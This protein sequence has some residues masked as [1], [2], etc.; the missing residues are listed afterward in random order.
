MRRYFETMAYIIIV[1]PAILEAA[2]LPRGPSMVATI[3]S[4]AFGSVLMGL[5]ARRPFAVAPYMGENAFIA[6]MTRRVPGAIVI[7]VLATTALS[8]LFRVSPAP[9]R[10]VSLPPDP[11]PV[12]FGSTSGRFSAPVSFPWSSR[13]S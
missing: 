7:G 2:G 13:S 5:Y 9:G 6:L 8:F 1:N 3:L 12:M 10:W 11:V 4:S